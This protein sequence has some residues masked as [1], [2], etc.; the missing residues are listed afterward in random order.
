LFLPDIEWPQGKHKI[1]DDAAEVIR[2]LLNKNP[3]ERAT[4]NGE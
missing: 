1:P 2:K 4:S 3:N